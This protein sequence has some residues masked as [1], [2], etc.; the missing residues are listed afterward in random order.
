MIN[1]SDE[2]VSYASKEKPHCVIV[3]VL[4]KEGKKTN[5]A[6]SPSIA[7]IEAIHTQHN[8]RISQKR[9]TTTVYQVH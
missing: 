6:R 4:T 9:Y 1:D 2:F 5:D 7:S 8:I 3:S